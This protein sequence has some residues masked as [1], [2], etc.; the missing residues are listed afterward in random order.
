MLCLLAGGMVIRLTVNA[1]AAATQAP[2][3]FKWTIT[4]RN[5]FDRIAHMRWTLGTSGCSLPSVPVL[6][7]RKRCFCFGQ[8]Q[9]IRCPPS[10][11]SRGLIAVGGNA[12]TWL[13][14]G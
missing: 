7:L 5:I 2:S 9:V 6:L 8:P 12:L 13:V 11:L 14:T 3:I 4:H 10:T 1:H